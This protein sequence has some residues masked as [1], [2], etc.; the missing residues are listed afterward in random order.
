[1]IDVTPFFA[2]ALELVV[3]GALVAL[4]LALLVTGEK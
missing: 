4:L 2:F 1:M 3:P